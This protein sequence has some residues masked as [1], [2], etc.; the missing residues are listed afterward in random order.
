[1]TSPQAKTRS[2]P[3]FSDLIHFRKEWKEFHQNQDRENADRVFRLAGVELITELDLKFFPSLFRQK[4]NEFGRDWE[5]PLAVTALREG[6]VFYR[7]ELLINVEK[8]TELHHW[9]ENCFSAFVDSGQVLGTSLFFES[10]GLHALKA[11]VWN[12]LFYFV[13]HPSKDPESLTL[14]SAPAVMTPPQF[15]RIA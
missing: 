12:S 4:L 5:R 2:K 9:L 8:V 3:T 15:L 13:L 7:A 6:Y 1:M 14:G 10:N 11:G